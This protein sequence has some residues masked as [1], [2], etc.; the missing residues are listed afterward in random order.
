MENLFKAEVPLLYNPY[1]QSEILCALESLI[2]LV[3][4]SERGNNLT[5]E[6]HNWK[7]EYWKYYDELIELVGGYNYYITENNLPIPLIQLAVDDEKTSLLKS[8]SQYPVYKV[9]VCG[10][11]T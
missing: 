5:I 4:S 11:Q 9:T 1:D 2:E 3:R 7:D 10:G 8:G 6:E